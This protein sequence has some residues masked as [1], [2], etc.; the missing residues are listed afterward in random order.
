M[1]RV[2]DCITN[3][4]DWRLVLLAAL[5]C[6]ATSLTA[7]HAYGYAMRE[8]GSRRMAWVSLTAIAAATGIWA[9]H[10]VGMLAYDPDQPTNYDAT[11]TI[12]SLL[13]AVAATTAG[14]AVAARGTRW[15]VA[16]GGAI[17]GSGV[18]L[19]HFTGMQALS[20]PGVLSWDR[21]LVAAAII[22]G[23]VSAASAMMVSH[24][25]KHRSARWIAPALLTLAICGLH[26][27]AMGG[28]TISSRTPA[29]LFSRRPSKA[30]RSPSR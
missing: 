18:G 25:L 8:Q 5:I 11:L 26:F 13:I 10:F 27:T 24:E 19:M 1:F 23:V 7:L 3:E 20:V 29:S 21:G 28:V 14:F 6:A 16:A 30:R 2:L 4:H 22:V 15:T 9:T 12:G 17:I